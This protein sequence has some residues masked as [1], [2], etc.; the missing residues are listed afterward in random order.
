MDNMFFDTS[1]VFRPYLTEGETILW[2]DRPAVR[3]KLSIKDAPGMLFGMFFLAFAIFWTAM[4]SSATSGGAVSFMPIFGVPFIAVGFYT[5]F[6]APF[7]S[8]RMRNNSMYAITN[9]KVYIF[10]AS[11]RGKMVSYDLSQISNI[12]LEMSDDDTGTL[13]FQTGQYRSSGSRGMGYRVRPIYDGFYNI[14]NTHVAFK[15]LNEQMEVR[16]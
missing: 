12:T 9:R 13:R 1:T 6:I 2:T 8:I 15:I 10:Y 5:A 14:N 3:S 11:N 4:A 7:K 16:R